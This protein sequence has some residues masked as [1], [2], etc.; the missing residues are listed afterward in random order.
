MLVGETRWFLFV[1]RLAD[2]SAERLST[3]SSP[4][5]VFCRVFAF[6]L[7][8]EALGEAPSALGLALLGL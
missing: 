6:W 2:A 4:Y 3:V 5:M 1:E 7:N 8:C